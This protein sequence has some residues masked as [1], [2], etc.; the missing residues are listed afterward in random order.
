M[1]LGVQ[2]NIQAAKSMISASAW[3]YRQFDTNFQQFNVDVSG[4]NNK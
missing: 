3:K 4:N 1:I 2:K